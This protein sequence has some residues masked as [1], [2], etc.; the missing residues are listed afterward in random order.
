M[1]YVLYKK[2]YRQ[3]K[4]FYKSES[5]VK[6]EEILSYLLEKIKLAKMTFKD[7]FF[8]WISTDLHDGWFKVTIIYFPLSVC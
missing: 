7:S 4:I 2:K 5:F 1:I 3:V 6:F 8:W